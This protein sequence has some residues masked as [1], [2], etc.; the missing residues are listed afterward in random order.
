MVLMLLFLVPLRKKS[1]DKEYRVNVPLSILYFMLGLLA[2]VSYENAAA[3]LFFLLL[4][5]AVM[6][7][8]RKEAF[9]LFEILGMIGFMAG[10]IIL[11]AAPGNYVRLNS[12]EL[13]Q[14][15]GFFMRLL[16]RIFYTTHIFIKY[17][18]LLAGFSIIMGVELIIHQK[19][20]VT[21][22][23]VLYLV[24]G[25]VSAYSMILSPVFIERV[26]F[27]VTIF[28]IIAFLNIFC[29][30]EL[31]EMLKRNRKMF[32]LLILILFL[33]SFLKAGMAIVK[34]HKGD[35]TYNVLE[36]HYGQVH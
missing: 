8:I 14:K 22:F 9:A 33:F 3:A 26:F 24:A 34:I 31:P 4:V 10:F 35:E 36:S 16:I 20:T 30:I 1:M 7:V 15:Y 32:I 17:G 29:K 25:I 2:G 12:Y 19:K 28:L 21:M 27:P 18:L 23:S 6:K 5:Y 11:L 13:V